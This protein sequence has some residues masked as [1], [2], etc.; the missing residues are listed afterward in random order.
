MRFLI[1]A[2]ILALVAPVALHAQQPPPPS[3][4][5]E[6][7]PSV[8]LPA[9]LDRVLR[10]YEQAWRARDAAALARLFTEDGMVLASGHPPVRGRS[11]VE[12]AYTGAGG[13]VSLR[14]LAY[15]H[16]GSVAYVIGAFSAGEGQPDG[17][18]FVLALRRDA[19][20]R[21]RIAADMDSQNQSPLRRPAPSRAAPAP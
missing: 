2:V 9:E 16:E 18:K 14:A 19:E 20:G 13:P 4:A 8:E 21:W 3:P 5:A 7:L 6:R 12:R 15:G 1:A 11:A 10:D 17:G